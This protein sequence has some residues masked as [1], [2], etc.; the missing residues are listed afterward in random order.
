MTVHV[1]TQENGKQIMIIKITGWNS[2]KKVLLKYK[3]V[4]VPSELT[5]I[6]KIFLTLTAVIYSNCFL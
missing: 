3:K 6:G 5:N 4:R 1:Y 2:Q